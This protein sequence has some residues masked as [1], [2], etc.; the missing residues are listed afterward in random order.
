MNIVDKFLHFIGFR[1]TALDKRLEAES[2]LV[3]V[4]IKG[5]RVGVVIGAVAVL[6]VLIRRGGLLL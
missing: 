6:L 4:M 1:D 5:F 3:L 2:P